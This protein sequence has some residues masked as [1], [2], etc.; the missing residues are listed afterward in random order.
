MCR[1]RR[2]AAATPSGKNASTCRPTYDESAARS[3]ESFTRS[4]SL[5]APAPE[6]V[7]ASSDV[8]VLNPVAVLLLEE[9]L[10]GPLVED[11]VQLLP[12]HLVIVEVKTDVRLRELRIVD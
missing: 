11:G 1:A 2:S 6:K 12:G 10:V 7:A 3:R 8:E 4:T 5:G 9:I